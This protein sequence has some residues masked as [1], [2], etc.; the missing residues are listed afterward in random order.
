MDDAPYQKPIYNTAD[1]FGP[2]LCTHRPAAGEVH[3]HSCV[4]AEGHIALSE[5]FGETATDWFSG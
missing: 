2:M 5:Q 4:M 3:V 1:Y